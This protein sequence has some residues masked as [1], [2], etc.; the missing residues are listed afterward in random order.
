M[1]TALGTL[2][3]VSTRGA[4]HST[5]ENLTKPLPSKTSQVSWAGDRNVCKRRASNSRHSPGYRYM[6]GL[7]VGMHQSGLGRP[8]VASRKGL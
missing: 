4:L 8:S 6:Q 1:L 2:V 5:K 3:T 7:Q